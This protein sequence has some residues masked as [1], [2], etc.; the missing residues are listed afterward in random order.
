MA[1]RWLVIVLMVAVL[2]G[3]KPSQ[4]ENSSPTSSSRIVL[5]PSTPLPIDPNQD[6][7]VRQVWAQPKRAKVNSIVQIHGDGYCKSGLPRAS[8]FVIDGEPMGEDS[9]GEAL[10]QGESISFDS[11]GNHQVCFEVTLTEWPSE[12]GEHLNAALHC[13][14]V[15]VY[16]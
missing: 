2:G 6:C 4:E 5:T 10:A 3:C 14:P 7:F 9:G 13:F 15:E 8:R 16:E 11:A 12:I 1:Q